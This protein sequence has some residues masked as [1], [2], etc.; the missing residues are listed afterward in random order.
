MAEIDKRSPVFDWETGDFVRTGKGT[1]D[2][3]TGAEAVEQI[4][5]KAFSTE[6]GRYLIYADVDDEDRDHIYG[7]DTQNVLRQPISDEVKLEELKRTVEEAIIYDPW[8]LEV[9]DVEVSREPFSGEKKDGAGV[10]VSATIK[11]I[12]DQIIQIEEVAIYG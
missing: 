12:F 1:V 9:S 2:T 8:V 3:V 5:I 10:Y 7:N 6:R 11:T 4:I